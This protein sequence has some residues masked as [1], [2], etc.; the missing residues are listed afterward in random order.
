MGALVWERSWSYSDSA[1]DKKCNWANLVIMSLISPQIFCDPLLEPSYRDGSNEG[2]QH[3]FSLRNKKNIFEL[4][5]VV[6]L[7]HYGAIT[8]VSVLRVFYEGTLNTL[9]FK[10]EKNILSTPPPPLS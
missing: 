8:C 4:S 1:P 10:K 2:S 9:N 5:S 6:L 7:W 3:M